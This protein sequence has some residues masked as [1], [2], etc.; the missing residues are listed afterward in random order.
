GSPVGAAVSPSACR[1]S[2]NRRPDNELHQESR[3]TQAAEPRQGGCRSMKWRGL[4]F[5]LTLGAA[6]PLG[7]PL[8]NAGSPAVRFASGRTYA[9]AKR[10]CL[11]ASV[12]TNC[13]AGAYLY[14]FPGPASDW[15]P[16][17]ASM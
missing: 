4:I 5:V 3:R 9:R 16:D 11:S 8:A 2:V 7:A 17:P 12:P 10:V 6:M 15:R 14:N 13:P 1:R